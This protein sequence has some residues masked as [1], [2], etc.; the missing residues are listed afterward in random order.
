MANKEKNQ[1][2][3]ANAAPKMIPVEQANAQ[4]QGV[5]KQ[6]NQKIQQ[7]A[8]QLNN[9]E[10]MLR[11]KTMEHLFKVVEY[12]HKFDPKFVDKCTQVI[13]QYLTKM[14]L[15]EPENPGAAPETKEEGDK[16][17]EEKPAE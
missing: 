6:A 12:E 5:V 11:D 9:V 15:Q 4:M 1:K 17:K 16:K 3:P 7:L 8:V 13:E 10:G 2:V 14:A